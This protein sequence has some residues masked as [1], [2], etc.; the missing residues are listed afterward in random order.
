MADPF[1]NNF[2]LL[3][4]E[5]FAIT[6]LP[7]PYHMQAMPAPHRIRSGAAALNAAAIF[8]ANESAE[9][10]GLKVISDAPG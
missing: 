10:N 4:A 5:G 8:A 6:V 1:L 9:S 3:I 2:E 7:M